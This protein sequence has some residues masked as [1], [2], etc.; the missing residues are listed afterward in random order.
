MTS[1]H[2]GATHFSSRQEPIVEIAVADDKSSITV[3]DDK[4]SIIYAQ[5]NTGTFGPNV[6]FDPTGTT[7]PPDSQSY[8]A[9]PGNTGLVEAQKYADTSASST[10]SPEPQ[11]SGGL[12]PDSIKVSISSYQQTMVD[13]QQANILLPTLLHSSEHFTVLR[14][15]SG[16]YTQALAINVMIDSI[17]SVCSSMTRSGALAEKLVDFDLVSIYT[18]HTHA[19]A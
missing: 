6:T 14:Y 15:T 13:Q 4:S 1:S 8:T 12:K 10:G 17:M 9:P 5:P 3:V 7:A 18:A 19:R 11:A 16:K 2:P